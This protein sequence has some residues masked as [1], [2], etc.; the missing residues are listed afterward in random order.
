MSENSNQQLVLAVFNG[1]DSAETAVKQLPKRKKKTTVSAVV[2]KKDAN[3]QLTFHDVGHT[4]TKS[5]VGGLVL[6]GAVGLLTGGTGLALA[7]LGG[8]V[9]HHH[10]KKKSTTNQASDEKVSDQLRNTAASLGTDSSVIIAVVEDGVDPETQSIIERMGGDFYQADIPAGT[11]EQS[12]EEKA[13][14]YAT[15]LTALAAKTGGEAKLGVPYPKI[16]VVINPVSGKDE[17][18]LNVLNDVFYKHGIDWD[19]SITKKFGDATK[20]ARKAAESGYDLVV[21]YGGDGTQHEIANGV[22]GSGVPM[23]VLPGGTGNG[24]ATELGT[25]KELRPAVELLCDPNSR[26]R[27]I[28]LVKLD[29]IYFIQRLFVGI[30]PEE[31]TSREDKNKYGTFAYAINAYNR[32]RD[33]KPK[34]FQYHIEI[35]GETFDLPASKLYVVNAAKAGTGI[36]V[37]GKMSKPDDG[38]LEVFILNNKSLKTLAAAGERVINLNTKTAN[39]FIKQGKKI[40]ID[41]DPDQPVWTDGEYTGRTPI[42]MEIVPGGLTVVVP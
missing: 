11:S 25:P 13:A 33:K 40:S 39:S 36:S 26:Q 7:A 34:E 6:G 18:I 38:L 17:S 4:P 21:G 5:T 8:V 16:H 12:E 10:G 2:V 37:T 19:I 27:K 31:Q 35:D 20:F 23:G 24:F 28:D 1:A 22:M 15:L 32:S 41:T 30:E 9:G 14:T 29:D 42:S 3:G